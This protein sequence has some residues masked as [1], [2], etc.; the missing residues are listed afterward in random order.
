MF[1]IHNTV[2]EDGRECLDVKMYESLTRSEESLLSHTRVYSDAS[3][4]LTQRILF[5]RGAESTPG[6]NES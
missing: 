4:R 6:G 5:R 1:V 3:G 2:H